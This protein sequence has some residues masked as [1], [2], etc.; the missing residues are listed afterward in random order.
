MG[1]ESSCCAPS[2]TSLSLTQPPTANRLSRQQRD[3]FA[4]LEGYIPA[5]GSEIDLQDTYKMSNN[6]SDPNDQTRKQAS[7]THPGRPVV[8]E[9]DGPDGEASYVSKEERAGPSNN[10]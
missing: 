9:S 5:D 7:G 10:P 1:N 8:Y 6:S 2:K 3:P 4:N